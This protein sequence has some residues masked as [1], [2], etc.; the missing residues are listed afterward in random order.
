MT[1]YSLKFWVGDNS[2]SC[3]A[4]FFEEHYEYGVPYKVR[5]TAVLPEPPTEDMIGR[6]ALTEIV[7]VLR[8]ATQDA[9][10]ALGCD[11][12]VDGH[13]NKSRSHIRHDGKVVEQAEV[14]ERGDGHWRVSVLVQAAA[15]QRGVSVT[16]EPN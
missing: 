9:S 13:G 12:E 15:T 2:N 3:K 14:V 7:R 1:V 6:V 16:P 4:A 5:V 11:C 8:E 10:I